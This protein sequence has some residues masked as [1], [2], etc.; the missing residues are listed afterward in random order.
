MDYLS[1]VPNELILHEI[2]INLSIVYKRSLSLT[3]KWFYSLIY[4]TIS[5]DLFNINK[6]IIRGKLYPKLY[7]IYNLYISDNIYTLIIVKCSYSQYFMIRYTEDQ[8]KSYKDKFLTNTLCKYG[9][10]S[11]VIFPYNKN[12]WYALRYTDYWINNS[13]WLWDNN[14]GW[15]YSTSTKD[16]WITKIYSKRLTILQDNLIFNGKNIF[17]QLLSIKPWCYEYNL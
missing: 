3:N 17:K 13:R 8:W 2:I 10:C 12:C 14:N 16:E 6:L 4:L 7:R 5:N 9:G 1:E 11:Y 15:N